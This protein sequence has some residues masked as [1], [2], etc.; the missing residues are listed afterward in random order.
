LF[1][2]VVSSALAAGAFGIEGSI[3]VVG[4]EILLASWFVMLSLTTNS[5]EFSLGSGLI[6]CGGCE[7]KV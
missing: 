4:P 5:K 6:N 1:F 7:V 3:N 2:P